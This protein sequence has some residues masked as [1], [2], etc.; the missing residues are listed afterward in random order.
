MSSIFDEVVVQEGKSPDTNSLDAAIFPFMSRWQQ[1]QIRGSDFEAIRKTTWDAYKKINGGI[2]RRVANRVR[3]NMKKIIA[4]E[5]GN[6]YSEST[7]RKIDLAI[8]PPCVKCQSTY[9]AER[10]KNAMLFC[11]G[12]D[13]GTHVSCAGLKSVPRGE[14]LCCDCK[15]V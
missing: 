6:Y 1:D 15:K 4:M 10:G 3:R 14:W 5:G 13:C 11:E 7:A 12:C 2:C 9:T 8:D